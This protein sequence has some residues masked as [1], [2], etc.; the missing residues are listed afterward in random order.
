VSK[1]QEVTKTG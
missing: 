1:G